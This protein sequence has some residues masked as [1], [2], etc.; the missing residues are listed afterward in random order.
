MVELDIAICDD[1]KSCINEVYSNV[2]HALEEKGVE[3]KCSAYLSGKKMLAS[4]KAFDIVLLDID[5]PDMDGIEVGKR[6]RAL[7][8][9]CKIIMVTSQKERFKE[10]FRFQAFR[11]V[12]KPINK[13]EL[14]EA[15]LSAIKLPLGLEWIELNCNRLPVKIR[16]RDIL[17]V[18]AING[19]VEAIVGEKVCRKELSLSAMKK[20]LDPELF[21]QINR[22][23]IVNL[24]AITSINDDS[25]ILGSIEIP[26][27]TRT[28][29][30]FK[31]K[32]MEYDV[33]YGML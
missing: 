9:K 30:D 13:A 11:Y 24:G 8:N 18:R 14:K 22:Q 7:N 27:A 29:H 19:C 33:N 6:L 16:Q 17:Y 15:L 10:T 32:Y 3:M 23:N 20:E 21:Y 4:G 25:V 28:R 2:K 26:I 1:Q 5:M 12:T 31:Q